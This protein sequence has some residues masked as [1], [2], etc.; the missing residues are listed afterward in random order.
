MKTKN[1]LLSSFQQRAENQVSVDG[2]NI[3]FNYD[4]KTGITAITDPG[5]LINRSPL[6]T[7]NALFKWKESYS[8]EQSLPIDTIE[9]DNLSSWKTDQRV[10]LRQLNINSIL[11]NGS[12]YSAALDAFNI[13]SNEENISIDFHSIQ[14]RFSGALSNIK[15]EDSGIASSSARSGLKGGLFLNPNGGNVYLGDAW[16]PAASSKTHQ[17]GIFA[18][19]IKLSGGQVDVKSSTGDI[20]LESSPD[21][22]INLNGKVIN[23]TTTSF[24]INGASVSIV[25]RQVSQ[26]S[27]PKL[28]DLWIQTPS[29]NV[30]YWDGLAWIDLF[31]YGSY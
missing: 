10:T 16:S 6:G 23:L 13:G 31:E 21:Y 25:Y 19:F 8:L 4:D 15:L 11:V 1:R 17:A 18:K 2:V 29:K 5:L 24:L 14:S 3:V 7:T 22:N 26:P 30:Y 28:N 27:S 9:F 20:T 12:S